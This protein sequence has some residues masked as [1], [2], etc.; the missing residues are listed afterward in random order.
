MKPYQDDQF[1]RAKMRK[2]S[3][4]PD[5][6]DLSPID[7]VKV[8]VTLAVELLLLSDDPL[9]IKLDAL[10]HI[11][12]YAH[13]EI[14]MLTLNDILRHHKTEGLEPPDLP[15]SVCGPQLVWL[16]KRRQHMDQL[17]NY[18]DHFARKDSTS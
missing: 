6:K 18:V 7:R 5:P 1:N 8:S 10:I 2:S 14:V 13:Y 4:P 12:D 15:S 9:P 11:V 3:S 17:R 16:E